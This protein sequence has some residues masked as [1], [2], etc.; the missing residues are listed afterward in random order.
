VTAFIDLPAHTY[1][2]AYFYFGFIAE[3]RART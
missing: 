2:Y 3:G 1:F